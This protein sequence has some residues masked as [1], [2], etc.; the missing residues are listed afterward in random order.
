MSSTLVSFYLEEA[1][2]RAVR[3]EGQP[4]NCLSLT[5]ISFTLEF[6]TW[7][8]QLPSVVTKSRA[9]HVSYEF[10]YNTI[11]SNLIFVC[12]NVGLQGIVSSL[13]LIACNS[14]IVEFLFLS[15]LANTAYPTRRC[16]IVKLQW[17]VCQSQC[18]PLDFEGFQHL[19]LE[20]WCDWCP[21]QQLSGSDRSRSTIATPDVWPVTI[22]LLHFFFVEILDVVWLDPSLPE[23]NLGDIL[24]DIAPNVFTILRKIIP[25]LP[26]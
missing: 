1:H 4:P 12:L 5:T 3:Y 10:C 7:C 15:S 18:L 8:P 24:T 6:S 21:S 17:L 13:R 22:D 19:V 23:C 14:R 25:L 11:S 20:W 2:L 16:L 26:P 9:L